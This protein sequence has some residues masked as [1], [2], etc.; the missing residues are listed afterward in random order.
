MEPS[1]PTP[2]QAVL[3]ITRPKGMADMIRAYRIRVDN[4]ER[5]AIKAGETIEFP[6]DAGLRHVV[7]RIDWCGSPVLP[8]QAAPGATIELVCES[9]LQDYRMFL[10]R[11]YM[12]FKP[13]QYLTLTV[14]T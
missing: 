13:K 12:L 5:G 3:R 7:A 1:S 14:K 4:T 9:N 8:I 6:I 11:F 10:A 2:S